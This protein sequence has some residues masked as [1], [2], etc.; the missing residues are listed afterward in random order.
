MKSKIRIALVGDFDASVP[1]HKAIPLALNLASRRLD[2]SVAEE[3]IATDSIVDESR[4]SGFDGLW[5]VPA[6]PYRSMPGALRAIRFARETNLPFLGT[7][8][9]FQ[10]A[11]LEYARNV[12]CWTDAD[13]GES[14]PDGGRLVISSLACAMVEKQETVRLWEGSLLRS[15]CGVEEAVE[16]YCCRF[17]IN[18]RYQT[19]L[20]SGSL[21]LAADNAV[22][23]IRAVE[24]AGHPFFISTLFQPERAA[25][26]GLGSPIVEA[27]VRASSVGLRRNAATA[28]S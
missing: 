17:G 11:V 10:H 24:L 9:G 18:P 4:I 12:L 3:W 1:A 22:G 28:I 15:A 26:K 19:E 27:F 2:I 23:E 7:C 16:S 20:C 5:C 8:G 6:S 25:L 13:H 14:S 21:Q